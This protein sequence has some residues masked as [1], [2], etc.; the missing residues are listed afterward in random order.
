VLEGSECDRIPNDVAQ[1]QLDRA[2]VS[3]LHLDLT[4]E[5]LE[6]ALGL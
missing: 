2:T 3:D 1:H 6:G 5:I 4:I